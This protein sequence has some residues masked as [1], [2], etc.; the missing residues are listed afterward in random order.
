[1]QKVEATRNMESSKETSGPFAK[2]LMAR[3]VLF[4]CGVKTKSINK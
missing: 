1:M 3:V 4:Q 2:G